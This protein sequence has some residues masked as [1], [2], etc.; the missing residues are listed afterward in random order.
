MAHVNLPS[1]KAYFQHSYCVPQCGTQGHFAAILSSSQPTTTNHLWGR[2]PEKILLLNGL[3]S[4]L[5]WIK[6][7]GKIAAI[8]P[9]KAVVS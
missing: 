8:H 3:F 5:H 7:A 6:K 9:A 4:L 1:N 2:T